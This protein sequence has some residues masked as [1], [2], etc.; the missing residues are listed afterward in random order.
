MSWVAC[1][2]RWQDC[3]YPITIVVHLSDFKTWIELIS[4]ATKLSATSAPAE[5]CTSQ[6]CCPKCLF[7]RCRLASF[8]CNFQWPAVQT[9]SSI[10]RILSKQGESGNLPPTL[11]PDEDVA[12]TAKKKTKSK[13]EF[14]GANPCPRD[15]QSTSKARA[16]CSER[17][18]DSAAGLNIKSIVSGHQ[19]R[20]SEVDALQ[21]P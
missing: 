6:S 17:V 19:P 14:T 10:K 20:G 12:S 9:T 7:L 15:S 8:K 13:H 2:T 3:K 16:V 18:E 5:F 4:A 21:R 1:R 11:G